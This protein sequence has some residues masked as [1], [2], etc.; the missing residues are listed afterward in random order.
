MEPPLYKVKFEGKIKSYQYRMVTGKQLAYASPADVRLEVGTRVIAVFQD[1]GNVKKDNFFAGIIAEPMSTTNNFRYLIFF[2]DGYAQYVHH[3]KV[4]V[5]VE[6]SGNVWDDI[7]KD[8][9]LF[10]KKYLEAY[11]ERPMVKLQPGQV[12]KTEWSG[13][14]WTASVV[15]VD[16]SLVQMYFESDCRTEWIYRGSTRLGP[17]FLEMQAATNRQEKGQHIRRGIAQKKNMPYV[18]YTRSGGAE[19]NESTTLMPAALGQQEAPVR[20][21]ARKSTVSR[22]T[23]IVPR[24]N[25]GIP[26]LPSQQVGQI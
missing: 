15:K 12:V 16:G 22:G 5:V 4:L 20:A 14:W 8:S 6:S 18:E 19:N 7:H 1:D 26:F 23:G 11:P 17:L 10:I 24:P 9:R 25:T 3:N 21:V 2:D 13:K